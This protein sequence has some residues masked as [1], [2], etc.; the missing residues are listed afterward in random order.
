M[1]KICVSVDDDV[2]E[3]KHFVDFEDSPVRPATNSATANRIISSA[4]KSIL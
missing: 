3:L 1:M 2:I 4:L